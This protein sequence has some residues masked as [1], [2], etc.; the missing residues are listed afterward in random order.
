MQI[1]L[2][3]EVEVEVVAYNIEE[4]MLVGSLAS[5]S[6]VVVVVASGYNSLGDM[7]GNKILDKVGGIVEELLQVLEALPL[8]VVEE[9]AYSTEVHKKAGSLA[10]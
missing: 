4:H 7:Q 3:F 8:V 1:S 6:L 5:S 2:S 10:S 9:E